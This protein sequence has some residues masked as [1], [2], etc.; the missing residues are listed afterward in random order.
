MATTTTTTT[1]AAAAT[2]TN[3]LTENVSSVGSVAGWRGLPLM[4]TEGLGWLVCIARREGPP[5]VELTFRT[6]SARVIRRLDQ[7]PSLPQNPQPK[8]Y[9]PFRLNPFLTPGPKAQG[10]NA[11][12]K[13]LL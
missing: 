1:A 13:H 12:K 9:P 7:T 5:N 2:T 3:V 11:S 10:R 8:D 4:R 6:H